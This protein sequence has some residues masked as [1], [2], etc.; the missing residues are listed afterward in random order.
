M[1]RYARKRAL[2]TIWCCNLAVVQGYCRR[3]WFPRVLPDGV[4]ILRSASSI[5]SMPARGGRFN[6]E[7]ALPEAKQN[8][9]GR[10]MKYNPLYKTC[11]DNAG[12]RPMTEL[13]R[14]SGNGTRTASRVAADETRTYVVRP[15]EDYGL[16]TT[17][18]ANN[19]DMQRIFFLFCFHSTV[20]IPSLYLL[21]SFITL[22]FYL[23]RDVSVLLLTSFQCKTHGCP[24][25][26]KLGLQKGTM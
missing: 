9:N 16:S 6:I 12:K 17:F 20:F 4:P 18:A 13:H 19:A 14:R 5:L 1:R 26:Q 10:L 8:I 11:G 23:R 3:S 7:E 15:A 25:A 22:R 2:P 21:S 24:D